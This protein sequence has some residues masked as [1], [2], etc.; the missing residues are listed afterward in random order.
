[1]RLIPTL[2]RLFPYRTFHHRTDGDYLTRYTLFK[3]RWFNVYLHQFHRG[4]ADP[5][6][7]DHPWHFASLI[8][9]GGYFEQMHYG[10]F[11]RRPGQLLLRPARTA[12]RVI[13]RAGHPA[14]SLVV[15]SR[16]VRE[17]GFWTP[18]GW[19]RWCLHINE[20]CPE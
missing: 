15:T 6:L 14:W 11:W 9:A 16:K 17:W 3:T 19:V 13:L 8:L 18:G 2:R 1:M 7:H 5:E 10:T 20:K 4:D 12:H